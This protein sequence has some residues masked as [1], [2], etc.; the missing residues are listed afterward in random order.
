[1]LRIALS[2]L[3][4]LALS[5]VAEAQTN[6]VVLGSGRVGFNMQNVT[7]QPAYT[8]TDVQGF[9]YRA[10]MPSTST[11]PITVTH[12]CTAT[13]TAGVF[14]CTFPLMALPL[15]TTTYQTLAITSGIVAADGVVESAKANAP[16][17]LRQAVPPASPQTGMSILPAP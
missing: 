15:T 10:Y 2:L 9:T 6:I 7:G 5:Q 12:T 14:Q 13:A 4:C 17:A 16:F 8:L 11:T 3:V 1:M